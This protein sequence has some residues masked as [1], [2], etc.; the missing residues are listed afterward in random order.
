MPGPQV[1]G[2]NQDATVE[3]ANE[4]AKDRWKSGRELELWR[5]MDQTWD[6]IPPPYYPL[7]GC[8]TSEPQI[9]YLSQIL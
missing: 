5:Q 1:W 9:S 7:V 8:L 6:Q 4:P 2:D 3:A